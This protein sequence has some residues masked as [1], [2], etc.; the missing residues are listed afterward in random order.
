M[1]EIE[2]KARVRDP[3]KIR[4]FFSS[5]L[6]E[7]KEVHKTD[8]YF[9]RPG[10]HVQAFRIRLFN[11]SMELTAKKTSISPEGERN[12]EYEFRVFP[13]QADS[14]AL[15]F[16]ALGYEDFF[17]KR[18]NGWEWMDGR[19]HAELLEVNSLGWFLEIEILLPF[20]T[21]DAEAEE[22]REEIAAI[23][24]EAGLS[25]S[26]YENRSYRDMILESENGIQG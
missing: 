26:D 13:D 21:S 5:R 9:R 17:I 12:E 6:G 3:E 10:E 20:G 24:R 16:H 11:G 8:Y 1:R 23:M 19:A 15:F 4:A 2:I 14:A 18:K 7:G 25:E 22:A